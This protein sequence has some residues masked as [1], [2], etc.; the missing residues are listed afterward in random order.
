M[1]L[2]IIYAWLIAGTLLNLYSLGILLHLRY[3]DPMPL[4]LVPSIVLF[5]VYAVIVYLFAPYY[6]INSPS[7]FVKR[8]TRGYVMT[9]KEL[10]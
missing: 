8:M 5:T 7:S 9:K 10:E 2:F 6:L 3:K 1:F 4:E